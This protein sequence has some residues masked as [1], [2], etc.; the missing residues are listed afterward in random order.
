M[1]DKTKFSFE[2]SGHDKEG[3]LAGN[4]RQARNKNGGCC[5]VAGKQGLKAMLLNTRGGRGVRKDWCNKRELRGGRIN[6][7]WVKEGVVNDIKRKGGKAKGE[8]KSKNGCI[9]LERGKMRK[10]ENKS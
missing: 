6:Q 3:V 9:C 2:W 5:A 4:F 7:V 1:G 8:V 10:L